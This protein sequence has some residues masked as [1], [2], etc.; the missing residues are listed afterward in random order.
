VDY[1]EELKKNDPTRPVYLNLGQGVSYIDWVGRGECK[2]DTLSYPE[3]I[4][5]CDIIS[6]DIYPVTSKY[7]VIRNNL[8]YVP[9]GIDNLRRWSEDKKPVWCW[10]ETTH[11]NS[12]N[13]PSPSQVRAEVWMALIHGAKGFG[14]FCHEWVPE[15]N[16]NALLDDPV[17]FPAVAEINARIH[18]LAPVLNS[19]DIK[20]AVTV[21]SGNAMVPVDIMVKHHG[22]SLFVF[23]VSMRNGESTASFSLKGIEDGKVTVIGENRELTI[24]NGRF[25]DQFDGYEVHLYKMPFMATGL[26]DQMKSPFS[27]YPN[28]CTDRL[29]INS[30]LPIQSL[31]LTNMRGSKL[32]IPADGGTEFDISRIIPGAYILQISTGME[33]YHRKILIQNAF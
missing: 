13:K 23:A 21:E 12:S 7:D 32:E 33:I 6:F 20:G 24:S 3:Y 26:G 22:D 2:S 15:F 1:Y 11:I 16:A 17:M 14:Y 25:E 9:Y 5:G 30:S 8:W 29:T 4:E 18:Q 31:S 10:I 19:P 27:I 28:P